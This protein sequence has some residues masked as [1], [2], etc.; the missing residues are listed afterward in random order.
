[1]YPLNYYQC[2]IL[3]NFPHVSPTLKHYPQPDSTW[4]L[5][6]VKLANKQITG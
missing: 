5:P 1:M 4:I 2:Y 6:S 3:Q